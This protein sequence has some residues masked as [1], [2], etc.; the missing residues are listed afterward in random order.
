LHRNILSPKAAA[1][2][3]LLR[4]SLSCLPI[5]HWADNK[6]AISN[7]QHLNFRPCVVSGDIWDERKHCVAL[8]LGFFIL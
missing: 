6:G 4:R 5:V 3:Y 1:G 7:Q 2:P 8:S